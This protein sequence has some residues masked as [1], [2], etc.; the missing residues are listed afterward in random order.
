MK[1]RTLAFS[2]FLAAFLW[3]VATPAFAGLVMKQVTKTGG[4]GGSGMNATTRVSIDTGG[5]KIEF[6]EMADNPM[7]PPGSYMLLRPDDDGMILVNPREKT[8]AMIDFAG[9]MQSTSGMMAGMGGAGGAD[10]EGSGMTREVLKPIIEK[11]LEEDGGTILG[12]PT[13]HFRWRT[14]STTNM[15]MGMGMS[16]V[17][18]TD[19]IEDVWVTDF[20]LDRIVM[21]GLESF[22]GAS[23][24]SEFAE[25]V[26]AKKATQK[27]LP[28]KQIVVTTSK[29]TGS[30]MMAKMMQRANSDKPTTM[31]TEVV[32]LSEE[33]VPASA[34]S[35]PADYSET[36]MM[37]PGMKMPDMNQPN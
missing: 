4:N 16:M 21:R 29:I 7:M 14:R 36:E 1:T 34:F 31:T 10:G 23:V 13:R 28:L 37:S 15:S 3:V 27:G 19:S 30:G 32:E 9:L 18:E 20:A 5:A 22:G 17:T 11:L 6:L 12:R 26:E 25:F 24:P 35:I 2:P 33:K 8:Y